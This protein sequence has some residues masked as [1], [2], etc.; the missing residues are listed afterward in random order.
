MALDWLRALDGGERSRAGVYRK[1]GDR[2]GSISFFSRLPCAVEGEWAEGEDV[3]FS[4]WGELLCVWPP[5]GSDS[6]GRTVCSVLSCPQYMTVGDCIWASGRIKPRTWHVLLSA[7]CLVSIYTPNDTP[8]APRQSFYCSFMAI[9]SGRSPAPAIGVIA[10]LS[11]PSRTIA[12]AHPWTPICWE[13]RVHADATGRGRASDWR[14]A[15]LQ[16]LSRGPDVPDGEHK[17]SCRANMMLL[18]SDCGRRSPS[19]RSNCF[20]APS[21]SSSSTTMTPQALIRHQLPPPNIAKRRD[22]IGQ[23]T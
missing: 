2:G 14:Y 20:R 22:V 6:H 10:P 3:P 5:G 19:L 8:L 9:N 17:G 21:H 12:G 18:I 15:A 11:R 7:M 4:G 16:C 23:H 13:M 1:G